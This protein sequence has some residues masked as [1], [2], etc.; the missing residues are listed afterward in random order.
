MNRFQGRENISVQ[1]VFIQQSHWIQCSENVKLFVPLI[2]SSMNQRRAATA[3]IFE[4]THPRRKLFKHL[5]IAQHLFLL[6]FCCFDFVYSSLSRSASFI[7]RCLNL[8]PTTLI[9]QHKRM[10]ESLNEKHNLFISGM[11]QLPGQHYWAWRSEDRLLDWTEGYTMKVLFLTCLFP[12]QRY[13]GFPT[14]PAYL[15]VVVHVFGTLPVT[16]MGGFFKQCFD[17]HRLL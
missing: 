3:A 6:W 1:L 16:F 5:S 4:M 14:R 7:F 2:C 11:S 13:V 8:F 17:G 9:P 12:R 15:A 10:K